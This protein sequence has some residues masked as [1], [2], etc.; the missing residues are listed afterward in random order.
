MDLTPI[1]CTFLLS[2]KGSKHIS[3]SRRPPSRLAYRL[4]K[5]ELLEIT[6][7]RNLTAVFFFLSCALALYT[8]YTLIYRS[9]MH[10]EFELKIWVDVGENTLLKSIFELSKVEKE[11]DIQTVYT[12]IQRRYT[13]DMCKKCELK[14]KVQ[15]RRF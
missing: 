8:V 14:V 2:R 10:R 11:A 15:G 7:C 9:K 4:K 6:V 3:S 1:P 13:L 5:N 12:D